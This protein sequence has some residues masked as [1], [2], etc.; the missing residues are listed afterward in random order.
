[1]DRSAADKPAVDKPA[2]DKTSPLRSEE[3]PCLLFPELFARGGGLQ[4][5]VQE[6]ATLFARDW[7]RVLLLTTGFTPQ[8]YR[9]PEELKARGSLHPRVK[10]RNFF[11]HSA[12]MDQLGVPPEDAYAV[13][14][15]DGLDTR[16]QKLRGREPFRLADFHPGERFPFRYRY[17]DTEGRPF[18]TTETGPRSKHEFRGVDADGTEVD[19]SA[20]VAA[21][22]D[23]EIAE[24]PTPVLFSLQRGFNDPVLLASKNAARKVASLHN[25]HYNDPD[26]RKSGIRPSFRP[27]FA[28]SAKVDLIV[29]QTRQQLDE[30]RE[31]I[32]WAPLH[33]IRYPGRDPHQ[34]P[35]EKDTSLVV[36]VSQLVDRKRVDHAVRAFASVLETVPDARL[37]I[38]GE[39]PRQERLQALVDELGVGESVR[40]M[41]YSLAVG[42]AQARAACV[43]LT[44]TFEG[45][46]RVVTE[47]MSRGT[48]AVSYTIRYGPRDLIRDGVDGLLV[49]QHEP[50]A[51]AAAIVSLLSDPARV[52]AMGR[53]AGTIVERFPVADF[54]RAWGEVLKAPARKQTVGTRARELGKRVS[55]SRTAKRLRRLTRALR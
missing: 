38:Y 46:P 14:G 11:A 31:D 26:N 53:E 55:G 22:V 35:V 17:F 24:L 18:L 41:G 33:A 37:E 20:V 3:T 21:W 36:L 5:S 19:W 23:E 8:W 48:P 54:E 49:D 10:I 27:L 51:L 43:L 42:Q 47:S 16:P 28:Q 32:P 6:R 9:V 40:L 30:L 2:V 7:E 52:L 50:A 1:M 15:E 12:W 34:E 25:C 45:S 13:P 29:C 4:R 44:S 39:G